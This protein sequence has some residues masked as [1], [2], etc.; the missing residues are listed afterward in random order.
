MSLFDT[1]IEAAKLVESFRNPNINHWI[2]LINPVLEAA[3][4]A[5]IRRDE[6][7][8][9]IYVSKAGGD[10]AI[11]TEF[12]DI[13]QNSFTKQ[14]RI[15]VRIIEGDD[16]ISLAKKYRIHNEYNTVQGELLVARQRV[17]RLEDRLESLLI[18]KSFV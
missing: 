15:P 8:D 3:G 18:D 13:N 9:D 6:I 5:V 4:V 12:T 7:I 10:L 16:P 11:T 17:R 14:I 2:E 1:T